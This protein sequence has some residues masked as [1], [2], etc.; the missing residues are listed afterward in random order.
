MRWPDLRKIP[1]EWRQMLKNPF[2]P[3]F[4]SMILQNKKLTRATDICLSRYFE[5]RSYF[6][7]HFESTGI[8]ESPQGHSHQQPSSSQ[9][10][11]L[12][13]LGAAKDHNSILLNKLGESFSEGAG[14]LQNKEQSLENETGRMH[15]LTLIRHSSS[16]SP[17]LWCNWNLSHCCWQIQFS[18]PCFAVRFVFPMTI[19]PRSERVQVRK[20]DKEFLPPWVSATSFS[21]F[22]EYALGRTYLCVRWN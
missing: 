12:S 6:L 3:S 22:L 5:K 10:L 18:E 17:D 20:L 21:E 9:E 2:V 14:R 15:C 4:Q 1:W 19:P 7:L 8:L 11:N 16:Q 13:S